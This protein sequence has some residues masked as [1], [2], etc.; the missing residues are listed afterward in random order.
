MQERSVLEKVSYILS[1]S[2]VRSSIRAVARLAE[3]VE[4][5]NV[6]LANSLGLCRTLPTLR[7][8]VSPSCFLYVSCECENDANE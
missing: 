2:I 3:G 1:K 8:Q 4:N 6:L 5:V 7:P